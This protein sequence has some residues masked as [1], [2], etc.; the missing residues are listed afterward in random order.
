MRNI[1]L[2]FFSG[3]L[4]SSCAISKTSND[5]V[6]PTRSGKDKYI[7]SYNTALKL[8][9]VKFEET[10]VK[11]RFGSAHVI[12]SGPKNGTPLVLLHGTDA[13]STMWYPNA[14]ALSKKYRIY[15]IDYPMETGKS[16]ASV[17]EMD[18]KQ[19]IVFYNEVFDDLGMKNIDIVAASRGGWVATL[20]ALQENNKIGKLVL[21]SPA[22]TFGGV[23]KLG[24]AMSALFLKM[25][26]SRKKLKVFFNEF[27]YCP[28]QINDKYKEQFYLANKYGRSKPD[29]MKMVKFDEAELKSLKIPVLVLVGDHDV[30]N[31]VDI[32]EKAT[33]M[34]PH[35][36]T[37]VIPD[38]G[39]FLSV[40]QPEIV[41]K[42]I[43]D[44]LNKNP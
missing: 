33:E 6:F 38:A 30:I 43:L 15:A 12:M 22:Q 27:S 18:P 34:I 9:K 29:L 4:L 41:N 8:W 37:A 28:D 3:I 26:P 21:L 19:M 11:T 36:E 5:F 35:V 24:K 20:L 25:F 32:L 7:R 16:V 1:L 13:S 23:D 10:D 31:D 42:K 44:F 2:L 14:A 39:H 40:D 17:K